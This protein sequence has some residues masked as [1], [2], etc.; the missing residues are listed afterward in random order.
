LIFFTVT[1]DP[2]GLLILG[3]VTFW[4]KV[5]YPVD[6]SLPSTYITQPSLIVTKTVNEVEV[7]V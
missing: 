6:S 3:S 1:K 4:M 5:S 2:T 7:G